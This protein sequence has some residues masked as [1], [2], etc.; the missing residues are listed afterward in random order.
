M[1][2]DEWQNR[3]DEQDHRFLI[4]TKIPEHDKL[5]Y[6][7]RSL[8]PTT[9][10][11]D[12]MF[13]NGFMME[14][15]ELLKHGF[16]L[17][18]DGYFDC[19]FY[20]VRQSIENMNNMLFLS[21]SEDELVKWKA[22]ERF[23]SY[24]QIKTQLQQINAAYSEIKTAIPEI[25]D[26]YDE[27]LKKA[28]K[29]IHKQG[30]DTF[31]LHPW[32]QEQLISN[33]TELFVDLLKQSIGLLMVINI[34]LDPLSLALSDPEVDAYIHFDP[35]TESIPTYIFDELFSCDVIEK[36][37][38]TS[39][40]KE[41]ISCFLE[42]EEMNDATYGVVRFNIFDNEHLDDIEKQLHLLSYREVLC[43]KL[44]K[45]GIKVSH[46]YYDDDIFGYAT[47][48]HPAHELTE[49]SSAQFEMYK[50]RKNKQNIPWKGMFISLYKVFDTYLI[51]QHN[52]T[53]SN[54]DNIL[55]QDIIDKSNSQYFNI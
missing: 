14:S 37:K 45:A 15:V 53:L 26:L 13:C 18:E 35:M 28:N 16:F 2:N 38:E 24:S 52:D 22:K 20:S 36:I 29:Y 5:I 25:F 10:F 55:I 40:Y 47:C 7:L 9:G 51:L 30:F 31:Y 44:L 6:Y 27:L 43:F 11:L 39:F 41:F 12:K 23:P 34:I 17:Y 21:Q 54:K 42:K 19:A 49:Y 32:Q 46:F 48:I 33:R 1:T 50:A 4:K 3:L 8:L